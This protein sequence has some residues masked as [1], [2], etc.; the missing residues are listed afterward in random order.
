MLKQVDMNG[1]AEILLNNNQLNYA[2]M[3]LRA[4]TH[5]QRI[6]ILE[7]LAK[8]GTCAVQEIYRDLNIDQSLTSQQLKILRQAS[9]VL[10]TRKGKFIF[11]SL[12]YS[13]LKNLTEVVYKL[14]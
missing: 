13:A 1:E 9:L 8:R 4:A 11:Y 3:V 12:N 2:C 14:S 7:Y 6:L 5:P 10:T